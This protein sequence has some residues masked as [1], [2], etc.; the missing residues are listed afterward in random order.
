MVVVAVDAVVVVVA[1]GD[2]G[3]RVAEGGEGWAAPAPGDAPAGAEGGGRGGGEQQQEAGA[4][5]GT[6][7]A[8]LEQEQ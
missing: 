6:V 2:P 8:K 4:G 7:G 3:P 1:A 5:H